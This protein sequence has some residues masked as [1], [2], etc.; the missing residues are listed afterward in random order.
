MTGLSL[1]RVGA[2]GK[3]SPSRLYIYLWTLGGWK[4][5]HRWLCC[6]HNGPKLVN[7]KEIGRLLSGG[8]YQATMGLL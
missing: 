3:H 8:F 7:T 2:G 5:R 1:T 4:R 6:W